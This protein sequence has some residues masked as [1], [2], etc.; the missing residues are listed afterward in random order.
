[1]ED[2]YKYFRFL[3]YVIEIFVFFVVQQTPGLIPTVLGG[4]P[5]L[6]LP[7]LVTIAMFENETVGLF[8]GLLIGVISDIGLWNVIGFYGIIFAIIGYVIGL[9]AVNFLRTNLITA[10]IASLAAIIV[11]YGMYYL[12]AYVFKGYDGMAYVFVNHFLSRMVYTLVLSPVFYFFN[13]AIAIQ[14]RQRDA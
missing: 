13:K 7:I 12:F 10:L 6:L 8:F 3:A 4:R 5:M 9:L 11:S 2:K 1:M 14:I